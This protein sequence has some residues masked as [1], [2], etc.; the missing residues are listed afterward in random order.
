M[1]EPAAPTQDLQEARPGQALC[2]AG[3]QRMGNFRAAELTF[4]SGAGEVLHADAEGG[5]WQGSGVWNDGAWCALPAAGR[6][7]RA[8]VQSAP[9]PGSDDPT[10]VM[11]LVITEDLRD[12]VALVS[13]I[14]KITE[15]SLFRVAQLVK[16]H[17]A[18]ALVLVQ[19]APGVP[20][21]MHP[22]RDDEGD[23]DKGYGAIPCVRISSASAERLLQGEWQVTIA[24]PTPRDN[25][26]KMVARLSWK[27]PGSGCLD[28]AHTYYALKERVRIHSLKAKP[29]FNGLLGSVIS[30]LRTETNTWEDARL[31]VQLDKGGHQVNARLP[32]LPPSP[33][34]AR[35]LTYALSH[36]HRRAAPAQAAQSG[37]SLPAVLR[38]G[39]LVAHLC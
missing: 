3:P 2:T 7:A 29:H 21:Y 22:W 12:T 17:G 34:S 4:T 10:P 27:A 8:G 38:G 25:D 13:I 6:L 39:G 9:E 30:R 11:D 24:A 26:D 31:G 33:P 23:A 16:G 28:P 37:A 18:R 20:G 1:T 14:G 15:A 35:S 19:S 5:R 32:P 36:T